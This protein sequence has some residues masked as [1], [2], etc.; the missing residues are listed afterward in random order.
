MA[1]LRGALKRMMMG[2]HSQQANGTA[3]VRPGSAGRP[4]SPANGSSYGGYN[5]YGGSRTVD[6]F[7]GE[8]SMYSSHFAAGNGSSGYGDMYG[9]R[10]EGAGARGGPAGRARGM[11]AAEDAGDRDE[12]PHSQVGGCAGAGL[13]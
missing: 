12:A 6:T 9:Q 13:T 4:Y 1:E 2:A 5:G 8:S 11:G 3:P 10:E 7:P